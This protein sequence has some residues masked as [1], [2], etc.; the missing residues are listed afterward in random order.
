MAST[1]TKTPVH[2]HPLSPEDV[3]SKGRR[4]RG[5]QSSEARPASTAS[6]YFSLKAQQEQHHPEL[7]NWDGSVRGY[8]KTERARAEE[9]NSSSLTVLWDKPPSKAPPLFVVGSL[10]DLSM[11]HGNPEVFVTGEPELE[12]VNSAVSA[13]VLATKWHT[14]SDEAIQATISKLSASDS[15]ADAPSHPYHTAL[16]V[17]SSAVHNLSRARL[18]LEE[19][20][21]ILQEKEVAKRKRANELLKELK[22]SEQEVARRVIQSL[23]TDDDENVHQVHRKQSVLSLAESLAEAVADEGLISRSLPDP[24]HP[25]SPMPEEA[26]TPIIDQQP[27]QVEIIPPTD[28]PAIE[29]DEDTAGEPTLIPHKLRQDRPSIGDWMGTWWSKKGDRA[30]GDKD[31]P[32]ERPPNVVIA[33]QQHRRRSAKSVFGTLG[34]SILNPAS[35]SS[36]STQRSSTVRD[37]SPPVESDA[38]SIKS[39]RSGKS[40]HTNAATSFSTAVSA[41]S[42]PILPSFV[43][44]PAAPLI[45]TVFESLVPAHSFSAEPSLLSQDPPPILTQGAT[46][47]AIANATRVMSSDPSSILADQ[48]RD[49]GPLV[50]Q[51][52]MELIRNA[53]DEGVVFRNRPKD[54]KDLRADHTSSSEPADKSGAVGTMSSPN[55]GSTDVAMILNRALASQTETMKKTK[56]RA[57]SIMQVAPPFASPLFGSFMTQQQRKPPIMTDRNGSGSINDASSSSAGQRVLSNNMPSISA[58]G[59]RKK[60]SSVP[61]ES[62]IPA[63]AKPPT[64]YLSRT[65][66]PLT[67][68]DFRFTIP[69]PQSASRYTIYHDDKNQ[70]PLTDRYG[71]MYDVSQYDVL[72]LIRAKECGNTAPA[73][74]TGVKIAD[75]EEDNSWPDDDDDDDEVGGL[76][77]TIE[78]VKESCSCNGELDAPAVG[79]KSDPSSSPSI[80][81]DSKSISIKS[82]SSSKSRKRLSVGNPGAVSSNLA[83]STTSILSV[84]SDTPRHACANTVRRLLNQLTEIHDQQQASQRKEWDAFVKQRSKVKHLK[85]N[86]NAVPSSSV[87]G[88]AAAILGLGTAGEE[89]ELSHSEGLIGFAQLGL[90]SNKDEKREFDRLVRS[91]IPLVY[92]SKVWLECSGALEMTEPGLF[93]DLLAEVDG[94]DSVVGEIEKDV[95]RTMPLNIFFGGD[96]AGVDKLRRVLIAYSRRNPAVGYC[97]GMNLITSTLLL[98][99]ADEEEAFWMLAAIVERILPEDFFSPSLLPSRA[100]PLVLLDYVQEF[101]PKLHAHLTDLGVDLA[102]ICFSWFLSLF[103]DCLPV[104]TLFRVW[105]VF[106]VGGLDVLFRVALGILRSNETE[107]LRCESIPAVYVALENLPTRMW[108]AD[109][110][111]QL[112]LD[113]R[114]SLVHSQIVSKRETHVAALKQ[115]IS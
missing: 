57:A 22:P 91:G 17:L 30:P 18:E 9:N 40:T 4:N 71:F 76:K 84:N 16:R 103:T 81:G 111:L 95:G 39:A 94:P 64:H 110:L 88:G 7:P 114:G 93:Q 51:L 109:K 54:R 98:V 33:K 87:A 23:F 80:A 48:G 21:K 35:S 73:C 69:L 90:S 15:P 66:T 41:V 86:S 8:G 44:S 12:G 42:S 60:A 99:H 56:S 34:I 3:P 5:Q 47:R 102:A 2:S 1:H 74:L 97:Q 11:A 49:T 115:L 67:S 45:S 101:V 113:L 24:P 13:Q 53:R 52:A 85:G 100:C 104:E 92:R 27:T 107:L 105:D 68:R 26:S 82:R 29:E 14:Y 83:A 31:P 32:T 50:A 55:V 63:T 72:L 106:L 38:G 58:P 61:L 19:A 62:I 75:R 20:R 43:P 59:N 37:D 25:L 78:I 6:N 28:N 36:S 10:H 46:L 89:D 96:G 79:S 108:E 112:E 70:R 77:N 65:Y